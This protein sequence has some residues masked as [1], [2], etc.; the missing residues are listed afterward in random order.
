MKLLKYY[1]TIILVLLL[2]QIVFSQQFSFSHYSVDKGLSQSVI[3]CIYQAGNGFVWFGTQQGLNKFNGYTFEKFQSSP[4]DTNSIS[5]NWIY[6]FTEDKEGNIWVGTRNGLNKFIEKTGEFI[7]IFHNE[8]DANSLSSNY[9]YGLS[10]DSYG[11]IL[12]NTPEAINIINP[13]TLV[14]KRFFYP[15]Q[16]SNEISDEGRP[17]LQAKDGIIWIATAN[18]LLSFDQKNNTFQIFNSN[19]NPYK[20]NNNNITALIE[21]SQNNLWIGTQS[22]LNKMNLTDHFVKSYLIGSEYSKSPN[23]NF[24]RSI[25]E[26]TYRNIWI[27][28]NGSGLFRL[29]FDKNYNISGQINFASKEKFSDQISHNIVLSLFIDKANILWIGTLNGIDKTDLKKKKFNIYRRG[30]EINSVDLLDN[31]VASLYKDSHNNIWIGN[32]GSGLNILN[33]KTNK[34]EHY[35]SQSKGMFNISNNF[36]HSIYEDS[37]NRIWVG[38]RNRINI[39]DENSKRFV[40]IRSYFKTDKLPDFTE[41]RVNNI[42][43][44]SYGYFWIATQNGLYKLDII[45]QKY[46]VFL[47][48]EGSQNVCGNLIYDLMEDS[49]QNIWVATSDGL[50][51]YIRKENIFLHFKRNQKSSNTLSSNFIVSLCEDYEGNIWI[52][53]TSGLNKYIVKDSVFQ[54]FLK[55][56]GLSSNVVY[57]IQEDRNK[58]LWIATVEGLCFYNSKQKLFYTFDVEDGLQSREFNTASYKA[59][60]GEFF[61]GGMNGVNYFYP[62]SINDNSFI[63]PVVIT[64]IE[65]S[66]SQ[67]KH[68]LSPESFENLLLTV[69]DYTF[70]IE[71]ASLDYTNPTKNKFAYKMEGVSEDW[72]D[73]GNRRYVSFS[74]LPAGDYVLFFRGTNSDGV[75]N[76]KSKRLDITIIPPFWRS[77]WA[78]IAYLIIIALSVF[79]YIKIRERKL[80]Y[81]Q[82]ILEEKVLTRTAEIAMQKEK[83]ERAYNNVKQLSEIGQ[84]IT[85]NLTVESIINTVYQNLN[86]LMDSSILAIGIF[87]E[88]NKRIEFVGTI[89]KGQK[90][91]F[92]FDSIDEIHRPSV[93][94]FLEKKEIIYLSKSEYIKKVASKAKIGELPESLVYLPLLKAERSIGVITVQSFSPNAYSDYHIN[95]LRNIAIYLTIALENADAFKQIEIQKEDIAFKNKLLEIQSE[96]KYRALSENSPDFIVRFDD[97]CSFIYANKNVIDLILLFSGTKL[98]TIIGKTYRELGFPPEICNFWESKINEVF[99][100]S[101]PVNLEYSFEIL[102]KKTYYEWNLVPELSNEGKVQTV[103]S[104]SRDITEK[105][106]S[107]IDLRQA[108]E[109]A[110]ESDKL[111]TAFLENISHE[112]RTPMNAILGF[113]Q[114]LLNPDIVGNKRKELT[115]ILHKSTHQLLTI[116]ENTITL[117]HLETGQLVINRIEF[118]PE[119]LLLNLYD[120]FNNKKFSLEKSHIQLIFNKSGSPEFKISSDYTRINQIMSIL[121]DNAFKFTE[122]GSI[123]FGYCISDSMVDFYVKDTGIGIA[124]DKQ[125]IVLKSFTQADKSIRQSFGGLGAGLAIA[126]GLANLLEGK[127]TINSK[128][129]KGTEI[130]FSLPVEQK[131]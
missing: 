86:V 78:Y 68:L 102:E 42:I 118:Y 52:G 77:K 28:T 85:E 121:L 37:K 12:A 71:F 122:S 91:D 23:L 31:V 87:N 72:I 105:K 27:G 83:I 113:S 117:A 123:E 50:N 33:R 64:S 100:Y 112:V 89:E 25:C 104:I 9:I 80:L 109:K 81:E 40:S 125:E 13:K 58:N 73:L 119:S 3:K 66:N 61:F 35:T 53:T 8:N 128:E 15:I 79:L 57:E 98:S 18:G 55:K 41:M 93:Q 124:P 46:E 45:N 24:I 114:L 47:V 131:N 69:K 60:D 116:V 106:K 75:W 48:G 51:K 63:P 103:L 43:E 120:D 59:A 11:N 110:E 20:I 67:G 95:I 129:N 6:S 26:D 94:S 92:H 107:E 49:N 19:S 4:V 96:E 97:N 29:S 101:K 99:N 34:V 108:K 5:D 14:V 56:D 17:I 38:T 30:N 127:L 21:D 10:V 44:D 36:I 111:K 126:E 62:D 115:D 16:I 76:E 39:F 65:K 130:L 32:W 7:Q 88:E 70:T 2:R 90:L 74:N 82:K 84:K 1:P 22:G 54:Y